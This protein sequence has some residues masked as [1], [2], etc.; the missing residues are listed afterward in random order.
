MQKAT[1]LDR[2]ARCSWSVS[3]LAFRTSLTARR[4]LMPLILTPVTARISS[5]S[6]LLGFGARRDCCHIR[7]YEE[8][9]ATSQAKPDILAKYFYS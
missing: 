4:D 7:H 5:T 3:W 2:L 6:G 9:I 1:R 8:T